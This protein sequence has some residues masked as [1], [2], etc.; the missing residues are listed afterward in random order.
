M[1][2]FLGFGVALI[3]FI[4]AIVYLVLKLVYWNRFNAGS[5]PMLL[6]M[7]FIGS[8]ILV[9]LGLMGEYILSINARIMNRPLVIEEERLNFEENG[10]ND[11]N[12][13]DDCK[14][15]V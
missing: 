8:V 10:Q 12:V 1:A 13:S 14:R 6:G 2:T 3:S 11:L 9:F 4:I 5:A 15:T 7:L